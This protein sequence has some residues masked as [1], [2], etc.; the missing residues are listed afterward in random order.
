MK[1]QL[2]SLMFATLLL[3]SC[4][5]A[6]TVTTNETETM[7][8]TEA[9]VESIDISP[10]IPAVDYGGYEFTILTTDTAENE[11]AY[12]EVFSEEQT[13][14]PVNDAVYLR[15]TTVG[16]KYNIVIKGIYTG[17]FDYSTF[18]KAV[19]AGDDVYDIIMP[20]QMSVVQYACNG[21]LQEITS[22][23]HLD[24][25]KPWWLENSVK[26]TSVGGTSYF[27]IGDMNLASWESTPVIFYNK[28][29]AANYDVSNLYSLV[30]DGKWTYDTMLKICSE[31]STDLNG[32]GKYDEND[33]YGLALNSF[34][35][36]TMT[37]GGGFRLVSRDNNDIP[38]IDLSEGFISFLQRHINECNNNT[39]IMNGDLLGNGDVLK[40][41]AIRKTAFQENRVLFYNEMLTMA[42]MLRDMET[43]FGV[44]PM[45]KSDEAQQQYFSFFHKSNSSTIA[46]P[47]TSVEPERLGA[48]IED[49][50][51]QSHL[52][53]RPAYL[54]TTV[55]NKTMR[56]EES[57]QMLD[58][59]LSNIIFDVVLEPG[60]LDACRPL[61]NKANDNIVSALE[62]QMKTFE[63]N[64]QEYTDALLTDE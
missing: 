10:Q 17:L 37:Y 15:N 20:N 63:K 44:L 36:Y 4:S 51:Y 28:S 64:L 31:V 13:G 2:L 39:S 45:P 52:L 50:Q 47:V 3:A 9:A 48:V 55:K 33:A 56:D 57:E 32:N 62:K 8:Q 22:I 24:F 25:S 21:Y 41:V 61:F 53:V 43:D 18:T 19:S 12:H 49:M 60:I 7:K 6:D 30:Y 40:G 23:P 35:V 54:N 26:D 59:I 14:E 27:A 11:T 16:D 38:Q 34:S 58:M 1:K 5:D 29:M 46:V 42:S